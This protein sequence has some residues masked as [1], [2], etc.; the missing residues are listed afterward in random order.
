MENTELCS[1]C[2]FYQCETKQLL[3]LEP[4][5]LMYKV[6]LSFQNFIFCQMC[7]HLLYRPFL[8]WADG[9]VVLL[10]G[11]L[12]DFCMVVLHNAAFLLVLWQIRVTATQGVWAY[13]GSLFYRCTTVL[14]IFNIIHGKFMYE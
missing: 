13:V 9:K 14:L 2:A 4:V 1:R 12:A 10:T 11:R 7:S 8:A 5:F 6:Q 3:L